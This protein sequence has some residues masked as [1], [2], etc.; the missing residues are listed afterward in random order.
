MTGVALSYRAAHRADAS[1]DTSETTPPNETGGM[2]LFFGGERF[3]ARQVDDRTWCVLDRR[4]REYV[5]P[6]EKSHAQSERRA[7][8]LN[9]ANARLQVEG[10]ELTKGERD[11]LNAE[12]QTEL[13]P[14]RPR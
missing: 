5:G 14:P 10:H 12:L 8:A 7:A 6:A 1:E 4:H 11:G 2:F 13:P 3:I 9:A